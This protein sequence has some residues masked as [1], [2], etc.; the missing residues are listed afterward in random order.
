[1]HG[2]GVLMDQKN[3]ILFSGTWKGGKRHGS[4]KQTNFAVNQTITGTW[5]NDTLTFVE[6]FMPISEQEMILKTNLEQDSTLKQKDSAAMNVNGM[7][8][9]DQ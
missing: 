1:M 5:Q 7:M 3:A 2:Q 8:Y 6:S 4:G 9:A